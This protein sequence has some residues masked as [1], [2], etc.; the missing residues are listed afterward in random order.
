MDWEPPQPRDVVIS[1]PWS[2]PQ[3]M[4]INVQIVNNQ[5]GM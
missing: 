1:W 4:N 3:E 5:Q 2:L